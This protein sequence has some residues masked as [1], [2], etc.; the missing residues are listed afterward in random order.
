MDPILSMVG[1]SRS[2]NRNKS[3]IPFLLGGDCEEERLRMNEGAPAS[4]TLLAFQ[5]SAIAYKK[6]P[7]GIDVNGKPHN[8]E[9][10]L[11]LIKPEA[12]VTQH[13]VGQIVST[14][15]QR[16]LRLLAMDMGMRSP[17]LIRAHY[18]HDMK[19]LET[20]NRVVQYMT[21]GPVIA[22][23]LEGPDAIRACR[24]LINPNKVIAELGGGPAAPRSIRGNH[25][26]SRLMNTVHGSDSREAASREI[27]L[28]F[29]FLAA[30]AWTPGMMPPQPGNPGY[31]VPS[32][33]ANTFYQFPYN[34]P[35]TNTSSGQ[36]SSSRQTP[37]AGRR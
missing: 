5:L 9:Q 4:S 27:R 8:I 11:V 17:D 32:Q 35:H 26:M 21:A 31:L 24:L 10:T 36:A 2:C 13:V 16:G 14:F 28:W 19:T 37:A 18:A 12:V 6:S 15:E 7:N 29:Q 20:L 25:S 30:P 22:M 3:P 34:G 23:V 33:N 1:D